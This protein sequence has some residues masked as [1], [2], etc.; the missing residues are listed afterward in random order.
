MHQPTDGHSLP[1]TWLS[2]F[3][4]SF[5]SFHQTVETSPVNGERDLWRR[6]STNPINMQ[7]SK[8]SSHVMQTSRVSVHVEKVGFFFCSV[9]RKTLKKKHL[10]P[11][12]RSQLA[13]FFLPLLTWFHPQNFLDLLRLF[14]FSLLLNSP[15][16]N[17]QNI[18]L[19]VFFVFFWTCEG[20]FFTAGFCG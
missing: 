12:S 19:Q 6:A 7:N 18:R 4:G 14:S 15:K 1:P 8:K 13:Y 11:I 2:A 5:H 16:K 20:F 17:K 3:A 9:S 10:S